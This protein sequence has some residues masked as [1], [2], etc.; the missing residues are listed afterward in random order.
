MCIKLFNIPSDQVAHQVFDEMYTTIGC[1]RSSHVL[2]NAYNGGYGSLNYGNKLAN[3]SSGRLTPIWLKT[4]NAVGNFNFV[5]I[6]ANMYYEMCGEARDH[7]DA[8]KP[9]GKVFEPFKAPFTLLEKV[10]QFMISLVPSKM[11]LIVML[12]E[13][14]A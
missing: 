9:I 5:E 14:V 10:K 11:L 3:R 2:A 4:G 1:S 7:I 6:T 12:V 8:A 13:V